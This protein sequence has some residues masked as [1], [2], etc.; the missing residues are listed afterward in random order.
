MNIDIFRKMRAIDN[1]NTKR[2]ETPTGGGFSHLKVIL[3]CGE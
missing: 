2:M 3:K 1:P